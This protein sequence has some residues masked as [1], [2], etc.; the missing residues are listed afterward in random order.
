V[1]G[2]AGKFREM[3]GNAR[4]CREMQVNAGKCRGHGRR[5]F[6]I[7]IISNVY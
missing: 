1:Q 7:I 4:K 3:Q 2:N 5:M 6:L